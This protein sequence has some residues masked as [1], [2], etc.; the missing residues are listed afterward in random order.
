[1]AHL[2]MRRTPMTS[3]HDLAAASEPVAAAELEVVGT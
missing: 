3:A 1:M 2:V